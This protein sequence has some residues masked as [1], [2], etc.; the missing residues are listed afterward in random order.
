MKEN[1]VIIGDKTYQLESCPYCGSRKLTLTDG[2]F[3][4]CEIIC[5]S[6]DMFIGASGSNA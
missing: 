3:G 2:I 4:V 5:R 1:E 6:C